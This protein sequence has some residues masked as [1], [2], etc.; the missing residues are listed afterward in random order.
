MPS[1]KLAILKEMRRSL[2][3]ANAKIDLSAGFCWLLLTSTY[4]PVN[5]KAKWQEHCDHLF[6]K[7]GLVI[8]L[9][10][11]Q[12]L[13]SRNEGLNISAVKIVD[14]VEI[15]CK[16]P[17]IQKFVSDVKDKYELGTIVYGPDEFSIL[18][19]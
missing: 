15:T 9:F 13:F 5:A 14:D 8:P 16:L 11:S 6:I 2:L 1:Y 12:L 17:D 4:R 19:T 18:C 10:V 3:L 7:V